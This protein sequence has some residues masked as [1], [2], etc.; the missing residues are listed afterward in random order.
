MTQL[1]HHRTAQKNIWGKLPQKQSRA[2]RN[3]KTENCDWSLSSISRFCRRLKNGWKWFVSPFPPTVW[4]QSPTFCKTFLLHIIE[5]ITHH[6]TLHCKRIIFQSHII[7]EKMWLT[8]HNRPYSFLWILSSQ[9]Y[10][11]IYTLCIMVGNVEDFVF[12]Y[13]IGKTGFVWS[14]YSWWNISE[15]NFSR[16]WCL[17]NSV[18]VLTSNYLEFSSEVGL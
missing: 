4:N 6:F 11:Y 3:R 12:N 13:K 18:K 10:M 1:H 7:D 17:S 9:A 8:L 15:K 2:F 14:R 16:I 5:K